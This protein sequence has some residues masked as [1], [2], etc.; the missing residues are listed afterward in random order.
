MQKK[1]GKRSIE[2][3]MKILERYMRREGELT[4]IQDTDHQGNCAFEALLVGLNKLRK[5]RGLKELEITVDDLRH[6]TAARIRE[7]GINRYHTYKEGL[8]DERGEIMTFT[9]YID[10]LN[11]RMWIDDFSLAAAIETLRQKFKV[12][13]RVHKATQTEE[14]KDLVLE[15]DWTK[16]DDEGG[17]HLGH[18]ND[19]HYVL[20]MPELQFECRKSARRK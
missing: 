11:G 4:R 8:D 5:E 9:E 20:L 7:D 19:N 1:V 15:I 6:M 2:S 17:I 12:G 18:V 10:A 3:D 13:A 16:E 14:N